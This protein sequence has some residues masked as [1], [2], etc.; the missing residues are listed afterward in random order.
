MSITDRMVGGEVDGLMSTPP[1][2]P[3]VTA[4]EAQGDR[5]R[6]EPARHRG[7]GWVQRSPLVST[8]SS[9]PR[10]AGAGTRRRHISPRRSDEGLAG[11]DGA[12]RRQPSAVARRESEGSGQRG[13][14]DRFRCSQLPRG[15]GAAARGGQGTPGDSQRHR[16]APGATFTPR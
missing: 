2:E 12:V 6:I 14:Q 7:G 3:R 10:S 13:G 8:E 16:V 11:R 9:Q 4:P 15:H 1:G 5:F